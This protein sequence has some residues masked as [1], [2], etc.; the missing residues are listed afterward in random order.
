[1]ADKYCEIKELI[2]PGAEEGKSTSPWANCCS[3][4]SEVT[5]Q[6]FGQPSATKASTYVARK[7]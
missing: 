7:N 1:M 5:T 6:T 4:A 3:N 2:H